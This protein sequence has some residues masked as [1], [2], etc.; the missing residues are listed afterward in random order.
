[1]KLN[2]HVRAQ[3]AYIKVYARIIGVRTDICSANHGR[4]RIVWIVYSLFVFV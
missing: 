2:I 1:M 4:N 3:N